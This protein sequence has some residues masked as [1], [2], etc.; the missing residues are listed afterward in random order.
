M[1]TLAIDFG[2]KRT[3]LALS[4]EGA[5]FATALDVVQHE[6]VRTILKI[7]HEQGVLRVI[8][9]L[10]LNIDGSIG[11]QARQTI[12]WARE[13]AKQ[14]GRPVMFVD[15]RLSSFSAE[16]SLVD[17]KRAGEKITR[18]DRKT[19]LDAIAAADFLQAFLD[20][21]LAPIEVP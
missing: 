10:P 2:L 4:D 14:W 9:G 16:Q 3:G 13:L 7:I 17:R 1:R 12:A 18:K 19:R 20:G 5:R 6:V 11:P 15:E 8:V 21:K